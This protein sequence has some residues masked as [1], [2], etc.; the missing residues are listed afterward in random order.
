MPRRLR[1]PHLAQLADGI[2]LGVVHLPRK[3]VAPD[4]DVELF[5]QRVHAAHAHAV[6]TA[7]NLVVRRIE[8]AARMQHRQ[9]HLHRRHH[10]AVG[11]RLVVHRNAAAVVDHRDGVVDVDRHIDPRRVPGQRLVD[12]VVDHL[13]HQV[14]QSL[15]AGRADV[16][17]RAQA[18]GR[19]ALKHRD[20]FAGIVTARL[21]LREWTLSGPQKG[22]A[23]PIELRQTAGLFESGGIPGQGQKSPENASAKVISLGRF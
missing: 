11:Q 22:C 21:E 20:V 6:Q 1:R 4:L 12:R 5:A 8:L 16:H 18:H 2:A 7:R 15:L 19:Q 13:I 17:R 23:L 14:V 3:A 9:H 10:L